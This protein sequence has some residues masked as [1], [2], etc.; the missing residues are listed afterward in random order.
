MFQRLK[1]TR[2]I[3]GLEEKVLNL[4]ENKFLKL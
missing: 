4:I 2:D 3:Y 1:G